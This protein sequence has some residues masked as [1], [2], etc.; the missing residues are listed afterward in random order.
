M[1]K[2]SSKKIGLTIILCLFLCA[3]DDGQ[4][5]NVD[6]TAGANS[7]SGTAQN[8][9]EKPTPEKVVEKPKVEITIKDFKLGMSAKEITGVIKK[10]GLKYRHRR[11]SLVGCRRCLATWATST[12]RNRRS[13]PHSTI[14]MDGRKNQ[15]AYCSRNR[16]AIT[17]VAGSDGA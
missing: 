11:E 6:P 9:I 4:P 5:T 10:V 3:C 2:Q 8:V 14:C 13:S 16:F 1:K 7:S 17:S 12:L 15:F